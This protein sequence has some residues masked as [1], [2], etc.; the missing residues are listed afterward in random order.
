MRWNNYQ[1]II[2]W[3]KGMRLVTSIYEYTANFPT[4]E[5]FGLTSQMRRAA[6]SVPSNIAEGTARRGANQLLLYLSY[7]LGSLAEL[8][9]QVNI[10]VNLKFQK[11]CKKLQSEIIE[12]RKMIYGLI[13]SINK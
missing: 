7:S 2:A 12:C 8:E 3:K 9:T 11:P 13:K 6:V 10:S 5:R 1:D 4:D